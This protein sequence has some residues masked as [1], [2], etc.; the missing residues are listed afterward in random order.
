MG[1]FR[2]HLFNFLDTID[3][4]LNST[5]DT[6]MPIQRSIDVYAASELSGAARE[7]ARYWFRYERGAD[8]IEEDIKEFC[9]NLKPLLA[10]LGIDADEIL[11]S[12]YAVQGDGACFTGTYRYRLNWRKALA[13]VAGDDLLAKLTEFGEQFDAISRDGRMPDVVRIVHNDRHYVHNCT[14]SAQPMPDEDGDIDPQEADCLRG[15]TEVFQ[16]LAYWMWKQIAEAHQEFNSDDAVDDGLEQEGHVF[17]K[18]GRFIG[19]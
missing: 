6:P 4:S 16:S 10:A 18:N 5:E 17:D 3:S 15:L 13:E 19:K 1:I 7:N 12:G 8:L 2:L 14:I 9:D 11:Y